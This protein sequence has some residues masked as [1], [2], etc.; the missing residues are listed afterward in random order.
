MSRVQGIALVVGLSVCILLTLAQ[1]LPRS[2][3]SVLP[4]M[5][6]RVY[7]CIR[8]GAGSA[9]L[10]DASVHDRRRLG[11]ARAPSARSRFARTIP[12]LTVLFIPMVFALFTNSQLYDWLDPNKI[13]ADAVLFA[14][15]QL[16]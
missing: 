13:R 2:G 3:E 6:D 7:V 15:S 8:R 14:I 1:W 4:V 9:G 5:D 16:I 10:P 11:D 12:Y